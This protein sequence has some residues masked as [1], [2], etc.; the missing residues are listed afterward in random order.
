MSARTALL[1]AA[2]RLF[3]EGGIAQVSDR[4]VG[5]AAGNSNH[6]AVRYHF[7]GRDGLLRALISRH[8]DAV[9]E[10]RQAANDAGESVLEDVRNFVMPS[11][12][13]LAGLPQPSWRA[14]FLSQALNDPATLALV[15]DIVDQQADQLRIRRSLI[16][17]LRHLDQGVVAGR[18]LLINRIVTGATADIEGR[19]ERD[20]RDPQWLAVGDFL[21]DAIAGM[22]TAPVT[23]NSRGAAASLG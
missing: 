12:Q 20:G 14:R 15:L 5:E 2:E 8:L 23:P 21:A 7:G 22:L 18:A 3:A 10:F 19:A 1:D 11:M 13:V 16:T 4:R 17:R 9:L 6:S